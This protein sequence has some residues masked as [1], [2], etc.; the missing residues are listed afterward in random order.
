MCSF[1]TNVA[2]YL[3]TIPLAL[4]FILNTY[5]QP[6]AALSLGKKEISQV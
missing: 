1:A 2:L 4:Y 3:S 6:M 5:L